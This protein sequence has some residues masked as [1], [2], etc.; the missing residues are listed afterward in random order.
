MNPPED[1]LWFTADDIRRIHDQILDPDNLPGE[2]PDKSLVSTVERIQNQYLYG[3]L[4][5]DVLSIAIAYCIAILRGH[6]F[7]DGNKRTGLIA[8][9]TY[10]HR[11]QIVLDIDQ[12]Y[13]ADV[14]VLAAADRISDRILA[15]V[16][17]GHL[18]AL[19][20]D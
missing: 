5:G 16:I 8:L 15:D 11:H 4:N 12:D 2:A 19:D 1:L 20:A 3:E 6:C 10:L 9:I 13:V 7:V 14:M 18:V 17:R